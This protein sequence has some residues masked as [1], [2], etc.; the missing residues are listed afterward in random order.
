MWLLR[1]I[2]NAI[3]LVLFARLASAH[4]LGL[5]TCDL[6]VE[7]SGRVDARLVFASVEPLR[8]VPLDRNG[9]G[10]VANDEVRAAEGELGA[11]LERGVEVT[12]DGIG[13]PE[14]FEGAAI[15]DLDGLVLTASFACPP[16]SS[17][18]TA[19]LYYL[20]ELGPDH[21]EI[22]RI[23]AGG[24][25]TETVLSRERREIALAIPRAAPRAAARGAATLAAWLVVGLFM[26]VVA[27]G[28]RR[29][30]RRARRGDTARRKASA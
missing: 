8:G 12:A 1:G 29:A 16:G 4:T 20:N 27:A 28:A 9:D 2:T 24:A 3:V 13:C 6:E 30:A 25:T 17:R 15:S 11:F 26:F 18:V 7:P 21:R 14:T 19:T 10:V 23:T 22:A 5:S